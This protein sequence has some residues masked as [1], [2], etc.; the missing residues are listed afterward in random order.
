MSMSFAQGFGVGG[1][2]C[3]GAQRNDGNITYLD[4]CSGYMCI[5]IY[6]NALNCTPKM[7]AFYFM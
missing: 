5:Y 4:C 2:D 6:Q 1:I 7:E 3:K